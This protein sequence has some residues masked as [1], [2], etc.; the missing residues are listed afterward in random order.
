M[1]DI[2]RRECDKATAVRRRGQ[3]GSAPR[4]VDD[5]S[6]AAAERQRLTGA[7]SNRRDHAPESCGLDLQQDAETP[8]GLGLAPTQRLRIVGIADGET[9]TRT[10]D[11][12]ISVV[13][14]AA[15]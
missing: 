9:R 10:G 8:A 15:G 4:A 11:T 13:T 2:R 3:P 1:R 14:C 5:L 6:S 7:V 12:T